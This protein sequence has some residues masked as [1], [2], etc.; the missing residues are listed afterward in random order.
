VL[1]NLALLAL[2]G[3]PLAAR[4]EC[5][6][7]DYQECVSLTAQS[8]TLHPEGVYKSHLA[9]LAKGDF[10]L[11]AMTL[12]QD[13]RDSGIVPAGPGR[14]RFQANLDAAAAEFKALKAQPDFA[15]LSAKAE[16]VKQNRFNVVPAPDGT[17]TLFKD[18]GE[19]RL[20]I[21][22][23]M[24]PAERKEYCWRAFAMQRV[25]GAFGNDARSRAN[26][27]LD[28]II[29][30]WENYRAYGYSQFPLELFVN[31]LNAGGLSLEPPRQQFI[32]LHPSL[33]L[34]L[35]GSGWENF[36]RRESLSIEAL[37]WLRYSEDRRSYAGISVAALFPADDTVGLA[38]MLHWGNFFQLGYAMRSRGQ[39]QWQGDSVVMSLDLYGFMGYSKGKAEGIL[40]DLKKLKG[41]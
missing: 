11:V 38:A 26:K 8:E 1:K 21:D 5:D 39:G 19:Q 36:R 2:L 20:K 27:A 14:D 18:Q 23:N 40:A 7:C 10:D 3:L 33:A 31:G 37:G 32:V 41:D 28:G 35:S 30:R 15:R 9:A 6:A 24:A 29:T 22:A 16:G 34:E 4:A 17:Y 25:L 12:A 13:F